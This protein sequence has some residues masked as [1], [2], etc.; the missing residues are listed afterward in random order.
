MRVLESSLEVQCDI[1]QRSRC[2]R[3]GD[4]LR[5][6]DSPVKVLVAGTAK[7]I[8]NL[9][10]SPYKTRSHEIPLPRYRH[11]GVECDETRGVGTGSA[12]ERPSVDLPVSL[13][14]SCS[15]YLDMKFAEVGAA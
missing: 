10:V 13:R 5:Q 7:S 3:R 11:R 6:L 4:H 2:V 8:M 14:P 1:Q 9:P 15:L 12:S